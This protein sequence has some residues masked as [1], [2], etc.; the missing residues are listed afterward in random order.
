MKKEKDTKR[1]KVYTSITDVEKDVFPEF[2][3]QKKENERMQEPETYGTGLAFEFLR[4]LREQ[5]NG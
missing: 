4:S 3:K 1:D 5:L 2:H